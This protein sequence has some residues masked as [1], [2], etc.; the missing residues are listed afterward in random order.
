MTEVQ[1]D[2]EATEPVNEEI[3]AL[4]NQ[5]RDHFNAQNYQA[6]LDALEQV[7][8]L[9]PN[10]VEA[11][12][13]QGVVL[14]NLGKHQ[15]ALQSFNK[16]LE[17]NSNE[18]NAWNYRGVALLHLGKYEEALSTFDKALELNPNYAEALSNRGFV[19]GKLERYQEALPTFDKALELNPNYA[20]ALFNRGVALE[21]LERYQE[22]FQSYDKALEL[23]PNNAVAWNYRGVALGK[24]ERYQEALPTFD[25]ALELNPNNAEVWFNRGVALV[26]LERYQEA[27]QSYE[28]ALKL[29]P[30]YGEAW[31][32]RGVALE[33]LER[34][35]EALEAFDKARELNPNNAESWNNRGVAL[36][37]LER[38]QE[39]FQSYD[40]AIQLN[41]NDAQAWYNRGFPLGKLERYE[42][43]FQSFD[44]AI[45]LNPNY[46]E[47]WNYR[48]LALGNLERYEEAFQ[49]YDQAIK[50]NP[51]YAEAWYNQGVALGML[52][53]YEEAFQF[54][55]QAIKLN[56]N[57]AQAWNNR[58]VALGNL[59]RY[60]EAFQSF[61][62]AIKLN[63]NHAE[64]WYNQ[65]VALGKLER[66]QEAL[67]SYDQAIK[68][69]PNYAEAW[70]NQGVALG[71]LERYQ[72]ALQSY[73]QAIKLNP[74]Y[75]EAWYNRGFALGNL[76]CYQEAF[77]SFDK[78]IQ[79]NPND[80]EA[81]NN[82]GFSLR[83]LERYQ[84][85]LQSYDK[86]IQLNPN[87]A[88]ALFNRGVALERLERY[89]EAFQSFDKAIQ[90]NPNNTEAWYNRGVVL[91]K[92]ERHQEAIA[93][94][95][96]ALVI[97]RDF[98]L[99][100]INRGNLI[101]SLSS[102]NFLKIISPLAQQNS[103]L[104]KWGYQG[105]LNSYQEGLKYIQK[106]TDPKGWGL[107]H[108]AI[109]N[110]HYDQWRNSQRKTYLDQAIRVY[111]NITSLENFPELYLELLR[112]LIRAYFDKGN[113]IKVDELRR[114]ATE[115]FNSLK[116]NAIP[117]K[118]LQLSLKYAWLEQIT[119]DLTIQ[120]GN[121][122]EAWEI[123]DQGKNAC[124]TWLLDDWLEETEIN[125]PKYEQIKQQLNSTTAIIYWHIS[126]TALNTFIIRADQPQPIILQISQNQ[127]L[128]SSQ[129]FYEFK[130]WLTD[131]DKNYQNYSKEKQEAQSS[132]KG[133][134]SNNLDK[135][136]E[137]LHLEE[138]LKTLTGITHLILIPHQDLHRLPIAALFPENFIITHLPTAQLL[139]KPSST[140][141]P[142]AIG[143]LLSI[144]AP[145]S[146]E[147][148]PLVF[149]E[150]ESELITRLFPDYNCTRVG[151]EAT[152]TE[153]I[154]ALSQPHQFFHFTGHGSYEYRNPKHS[155]LMLVG[156]DKLTLED[157]F[158]KVT[159]P[160]NSYYL[161]SLAACETALT[162][163]QTITNEYV[164]LV[165]G[166]L[167]WGASYV[168]S[169]LWRVEDASNALF[170]LKL[171]QLLR[172]KDNQNQP[173]HPIIAF[174]KAVHWLR[175]LTY[176]DLVKFYQ[177]EFAKLPKENKIRPVLRTEFSAPRLRKIK[178]NLEKR[179]SNCP[180]DKP[181]H[182][183][184]YTITGMTN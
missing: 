115:I 26:N 43:A 10:K 73:D 23:N 95:D 166:F 76:E 123:A 113:T 172:E 168:V 163:N 37:K 64:A 110:K 142:Q 54:Y 68:L 58:G 29:N 169:T 78:A 170:M 32:Y 151:E 56:P 93:S 137:I 174:N 94:Y 60:E 52:E 66:Y 140:Q 75:A 133:K 27:L 83:N 134:L 160:E 106:N 131:W 20:E 167:Y 144:E 118:K 55:D 47:A 150:V 183:A 30:N 161:V 53:R 14:F 176:E 13:G 81:W 180:Y 85:A 117:N 157:L 25:K 72:E 63:P 70:Y 181:Y 153:V 51:N 120:Q 114:R 129:C 71:K 145:Q 80:A 97:K 158:N 98:Y 41:L 119:V 39:A 9:E 152:Q 35:Q 104:E 107:L 109:G 136:K 84:E 112:D 11:W 49:S 19:L 15:E 91:G 38:Y 178:E 124:L 159:L 122:I 173:C 62:K 99:A 148:E 92:L 50:L 21:R 33:S 130:K 103:D 182:W 61:D 143:K 46:A 171:Y 100:W 155:A 116:K 82:R 4:L 8:T 105:A 79:L 179:N 90:L 88:E 121:L 45:K 34:Y 96:Q 86:A 165:S 18:A 1:G 126:P 67:Q 177:T 154:N 48:G 147:L 65:G 127:S 12:N 128:T 44:Q 164:G 7:L 102:G 175:N 138:I 42:E 57:H 3:E 87:Y 89:E 40:Q 74:N 5:G 28:K 2:R 16:A 77:Q 36:E 146:N 24:L 184:T 111:E 149:A 156:E 125:S 135:L 141:N 162:A 6:A 108:Q 22:A 17:L 31:N 101:Y 139:L 59:E 132:W 69:N